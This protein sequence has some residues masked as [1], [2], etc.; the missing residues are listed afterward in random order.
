LE[1]ADGTRLKGPELITD[2]VAEFANK[3][4]LRLQKSLVSTFSPPHEHEEKIVLS[5]V[6]NHYNIVLRYLVSQLKTKTLE[7]SKL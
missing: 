3:G 1:A 6:S 2:I 7:P 5:E 4:A